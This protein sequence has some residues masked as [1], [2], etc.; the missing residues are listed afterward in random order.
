MDPSQVESAIEISYDYQQNNYNIRAQALEFITQLR[1]DPSAWQVCLT[2]F[3]RQPPAKDTVRHFC[4]DVINIPLQ[5]PGSDE[6]SCIYIRDTLLSHIQQTYGSGASPD[7]LDSTH[8]Q[9]KLTQTLTYIFIKL[10][11]SVWDS[12]FKDFL[13]LAEVGSLG[14]NNVPATALYLRLLSSIHDEIADVI[15][16][17]S[18]E[19][20]ARNANLKD[21]IRVRDMQMIVASWQEI[22]AKWRSLD[23]TI[24]EL[25]L[26][27]I[28]RW[29]SWIDIALILNQVVLQPLLE[30]VGQPI[31]S[32]STHDE[33]KLRD[34]AI[35]AFTEIAG[36][37]MRPPEKVEL[38]NF[39][40]LATVVG[41][42]VASPPLEKN[43]NTAEYDTDLADAVAK[44]V[45]NVIRDLTTIL[46]SKTVDNQTRQG[47]N[48][49]LQLFAPYLLR[50]FS[51]EYDEVCSSVI[52]A[53]NDLLNVFRKIKRNGPLPAEYAQMLPPILN[54]I[55]AKMKFDETAEWGEDGDEIDDAEF[56]DLRKKLSLVQ[57]YVSAI[58]EQLYM[59]TL[60]ALV[61]N[62][63]N[64]IT[65]NAQKIVWQELD[66]ALLEMYHFGDL[67]T[68]NR[69]L[70]QKREASSTAAQRL[71]EMMTRMMQSDIASYDH[72]AIQIQYMDLC[73]RY[74]TFF[75]QNQHFIPQ[76]L[77]AYI[78]FCHGGNSRVR[79]HAWT[80]FHR[81]V[82]GVRT[83]LGELSQSVIQALGDLLTIKAKLQS[84]SDAED[85][86]EASDDQEDSVF[87][88]QLN[89]FEAIASVASIPS[90]PLETKVMIVQS[91]LNPIFTD[92]QQN[93]GLAESNN[94]QGILQIHHDIMALGT[95]TRGYVD[96]SPTAAKTVAPPPDE[97]CVEFARAAEAIL[98]ALETLNGAPKIRQAARYSFA[99]LLGGMGSRVLPQLPRWI[100][101]L[102]TETSAREEMGFLLRLL[103]QLIFT[104]K[105]EV[106]SILDTILAPLFQH[107]FAHLESPVTGTDD[108]IEL[109]ELRREFM[110]FI[111]V[112][113][114]QDL[115]SVFVSPNNQ[116]IFENVISAVEHFARN[117]EDI[118]T[119]RLA[120]SVLV[121]MTSVWGGP[122]IPLSAQDQ[123]PAPLLPGFD[124]F[125]IQRFSPLSWAI[126]SSANFKVQDPAVRN[127]VHEIANLQQ[128]IMKKTGS[129]YA[130]ALRTELRSMG[131]GDADIDVYLQTL[132]GDQ[133]AFREFMVKFLGRTG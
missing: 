124:A 5:S 13:Q 116:F 72:P 57:Q 10:Y 54:V 63:F 112:I 60:T 28:S 9:S 20:A 97:I 129:M 127:L 43:R 115:G 103:E 50:F 62:T 35:T 89:L 67:A 11:G 87:A 49:Q 94:E 132:R 85:Y 12:F 71:I 21:L 6:G 74:I 76:A 58:D 107:V 34:A 100:S 78:R 38:F 99:R 55:I 51:D 95:F 96:W 14:T 8:I 101:G 46:E 109:G 73:V 121:R 131:L 56:Q 111:L 93:I 30:M 68:K 39:L 110:N 82:R 77:E 29:V 84:D 23:L 128:E 53:V 37:K 80:T 86:S 17:R 59:D 24:V 108:E 25:C 32:T 125:A 119:A 133:K 40:S 42:L 91:V 114:G 19:E 92:M 118:P 4:L 90:L 117:A 26:K 3:T 79:H 27:T 126:P 1:T 113:L 66:V 45:N 31:L 105:S 2:L 33:I 44:L 122:D 61:V 16:A 98:V 18:P 120:F 65:S 69:G 130:E 64:R 83:R 81:F 70:Y 52:D 7:R 123:A 106:L 36:K 41:Q 15:I 104:F 75:E 102:L 47:A 22:L 88:A 48:E